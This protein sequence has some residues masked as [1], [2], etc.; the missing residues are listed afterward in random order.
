MYW[1]LPPSF[2]V[3][4]QSFE[5]TLSPST[6]YTTWQPASS[7]VRLHSILFSSSN[8]ALSSTSTSTCLPFSAA[9]TSASTTLE[10]FA[11]RYKVILIAFTFGSLAASWR[12]FRNGL[13][14]SYGYERSTS[15]SSIWGISGFIT[16][17]SGDC[18]DTLFSKNSS[19]LSLSLS[20]IWNTNDRSSGDF[21]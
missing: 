21:E 11:R 7:R 5:W 12:R 3:M 17:R 4:R 13:M 14:L 15:F 9:S 20:C 2:L 10:F 6:P 16:S 19:C 8:L 1:I 18:C